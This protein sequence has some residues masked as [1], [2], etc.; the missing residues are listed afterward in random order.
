M[1][2]LRSVPRSSWCGKAGTCA[3]G[4]LSSVGISGARKCVVRVQVRYGFGVQ[5]RYGFG[6]Q[7]RVPTGGSHVRSLR[8][9][10]LT[11]AYITKRLSEEEKKRHPV[12]GQTALLIYLEV[13]G[14]HTCDPLPFPAPS[15]RIRLLHQPSPALGHRLPSPAASYRLPSPSPP[16]APTTGFHRLRHLARLWAVTSS[17]MI[18]RTWSGCSA[19]SSQ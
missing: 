9:L 15:R 17:R 2:A 11:L 8:G 7:V 10:I 18:P 3:C 5:V 12:G 6:V 16:R 13:R 1:R 4:D 19:G 14:L